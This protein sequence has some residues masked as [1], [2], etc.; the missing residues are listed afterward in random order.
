MRL[1]SLL[2][3]ESMSNSLTDTVGR[4]GSPDSLDEVLDAGCISDDPL[5]LLKDRAWLDC[6]RRNARYR[7]RHPS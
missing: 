1:D 2:G 4:R 6:Q 3:C 7:A 5:R